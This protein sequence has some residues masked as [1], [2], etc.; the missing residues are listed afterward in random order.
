METRV[1]APLQVYVFGPL[2]AAPLPTSGP[3]PL[4][5]EAWLRM[6]EIP[7]EQ[8]VE[9]DPR[10]GPKGKSPW[11][12][13]GGERLGDTELIMRHLAKRGRDLDAGVSR[14]DRAHALAF[15]RLLEDHYHQ[16]F[17]H[18]LFLQAGGDERIAQ[19][20]AGLP[21]LVR[22]LAHIAVRRASRAQLWQRG[23]GRHS[24]EEIVDMGRADLDA[25]AQALEGR[26]YFL[27]DAPTTVDATV[28]AFAALSV[29]PPIASP[30]FE[31]ARSLPVLREYCARVIQ[32]FFPEA[33]PLAATLT[34]VTSTQRGA[35]AAERA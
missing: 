6:T 20:V 12:V 29:H 22:T 2:W 17:E 7:Y 32:R 24:D 25:V 30:L 21:P 16:I 23:I 19:F 3:F 11:I 26:E 27:G 4:K 1:S 8:R 15:R 18:A 9:N 10:K 31:H 33:A 5:L 14:R 34:G 35:I 13:D 28:F